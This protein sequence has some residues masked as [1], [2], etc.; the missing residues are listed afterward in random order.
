MHTCAPC[1]TQAPTDT[2]RTRP[3][4]R[5]HTHAQT[6]TAVWLDF[7]LDRKGPVLALSYLPGPPGEERDPGQACRWQSPLRTPAPQP[8]PINCLPSSPPTPP[9]RNQGADSWLSPTSPP[10]G[11]RPQDGLTLFTLPF[12]LPPAKLA[13]PGLGAGDLGLAGSA[14]QTLG[15]LGLM[16]QFPPL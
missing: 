10:R 5:V 6:H 15:D 16:P 1:H 8:P 13:S 2:H 12:P 14:P 7:S 3:Q 4:T 11:T 9:P